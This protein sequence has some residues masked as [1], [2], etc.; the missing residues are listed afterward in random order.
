MKQPIFFC[1]SDPHHL[2]TPFIGALVILALQSKAIMKKLFSD[3]KTA[4]KIE[5]DSILEKITQQHNPGEQAYL[6]TYDNE[7]CAST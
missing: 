1:N 2:V 5:L 7:T 6:D 4:I 3:I